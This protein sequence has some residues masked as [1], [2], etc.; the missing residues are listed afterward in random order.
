MA[1]TPRENQAVLP[2]RDEEHQQNGIKIK[3]NA[4]CI[5]FYAA[6]K[7]LCIG[8]GNSDTAEER[9]KHKSRMLKT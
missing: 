9:A 4:C 1:G 6:I 5:L 2:G 8:V 7:V 3:S